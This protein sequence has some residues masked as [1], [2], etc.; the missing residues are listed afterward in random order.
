MT[1]VV[2]IDPADSPVVIPDDWIE[3]IGD[4]VGDQLLALL[5]T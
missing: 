1:Q 3:A 4:P 2:C 5:V